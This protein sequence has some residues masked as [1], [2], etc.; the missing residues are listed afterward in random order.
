MMG[1][2]PDLEFQESSDSLARALEL[3]RVNPP[4]VLLIDKAFGIQ[5]ILDWLNDSRAA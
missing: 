3:M 5:A 2:H 1:T 4:N